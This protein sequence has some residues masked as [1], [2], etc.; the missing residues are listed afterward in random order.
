MKIIFFGSDD[1]AAVH[2]ERLLASGHEMLACV[3][4]PDKPQGRGMKISVSPVKQMALDRKIPCL[5]PLTLKSGDIADT[6]RSYGADIFVVVAYGRLLT[7]EILNIPHMLCV[8]VHGSL[9]PQYRG[10]APVNWAVL[11]GDRETGV[12]LQKM[13]LSLDAGDII[14]QEKMR[15]EDDED[16]AQLRHRM[17][18]AG[19]ELL[20]KVLEKNPSGQ[21]S[22]VPQDEKRV[23]YA[24]KLTKEMGKINWER[25][26]RSI[27]DQV[28]G[29]Q[30]WPGAFT[31]YKGKMLKIIRAQVSTED[32]AG[33]KPGQVIKTGKNG[34]YVACSDRAL[35]VREV[36]PEAGKVMPADSFAAGHKINVSV[37]FI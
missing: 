25:P 1:F 22:L 16:S 18:L 17:A 36:Q 11:N 37:T 29:L 10:A 33:Y 3:T 34:F 4:G 14:A 27:N 2:L 6:L 13:A 12:T 35:L 23:T 8:N 24:P 31:Y 5:Q 19:A 9:L 28:R 7:Q 26:V 20:I 32:I 30:P 15:I 21:F